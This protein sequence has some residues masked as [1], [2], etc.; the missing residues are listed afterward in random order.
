MLLRPEFSKSALSFRLTLRVVHP[1]GRL[2]VPERQ[3]ERRGHK[4][5]RMRVRDA[6][7][8]FPACTCHPFVLAY[9]R[10]DVPGRIRERRAG[11]GIVEESGGELREKDGLDDKQLVDWVVEI[12]RACSSRPQ[13]RDVGHVFLRERDCR[14]VHRLGGTRLVGRRLPLPSV[15][16]AP[17]ELCGREALVQ[18]HVQVLDGDHL[19]CPRP[20]G[21]SLLRLNGAST[22]VED[23]AALQVPAKGE[24]L[25]LGRRDRLPRGV[26]RLQG[27]PAPLRA[28]RLWVPGQ[29][30]DPK[31]VQHQPQSREQ[32][33]VKAGDTLVMQRPRAT[34]KR[35]PLLVELG[36]RVTQAV[37]EGGS[38][39]R[40]CRYGLEAPCGRGWFGH[41]HQPADDV[42]QRNAAGHDV[43]LAGAVSDVRQEVADTIVPAVVIR[44]RQRILGLTPAF[45][46]NLP[47][48]NL[49]QAFVVRARRSQ[50]IQLGCDPPSHV[51][52]VVF[53]QALDEEMQ[54]E[55]A[56]PHRVIVHEAD[57]EVAR[58]TAVRQG[59]FVREE[60]DLARG[61]EFVQA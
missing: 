17:G 34:P 55:Q 57:V 36:H 48:S 19:E 53:H 52:H 30:V 10:R 13:V 41:V 27:G 44:V 42:F 6:S 15:G 26:R 49:A 39:D 1:Q 11:H 50:G 25:V 40:R 21:V 3:H 43:V 16:R 54:D 24:L 28:A 33:L 60:V 38:W 47:D 14:V 61:C 31:M 5:Q 2:S 9:E 51:S 58:G 29:E 32:E 20:V 35:V 23:V 8:G 4:A 56:V 46:S 18:V 59:Q 22:E 7:A 12:P 45:Q 37:D